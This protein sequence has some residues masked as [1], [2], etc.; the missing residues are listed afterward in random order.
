M[1][2]LWKIYEGGGGGGSGRR[3]LQARSWLTRKL[4]EAGLAVAVAGELVKA[5]SGVGAEVSWFLLLCLLP[6]WLALPEISKQETAWKM[7]WRQ[8]REFG[9]RISFKKRLLS[10]FRGGQKRVHHTGRSWACGDT[11]SWNVPCQAQLWLPQHVLILAWN[12][13]YFNIDDEDTPVELRIVWWQRWWKCSRS[14]TCTV[15]VGVP[16]ETFTQ[17]YLKAL[18]VTFKNGTR[19]VPVKQKTYPLWF[20]NATKA[21]RFRVNRRPIHYG[22]TMARKLSGLV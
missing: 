11:L 9:F 6:L 16:L 20:Y 17:L 4:P 14:R 13:Q 7:E 22:F 10:L 18:R 15:T 12:L 19:S 1:A 21:F 8:A 2:S 5:W 3:R